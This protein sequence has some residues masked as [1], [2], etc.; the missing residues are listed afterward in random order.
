VLFS[1]GRGRI[2]MGAAVPLLTGD[3]LTRLLQTLNPF[4][5]Q[6][7]YSDLECSVILLTLEEGDGRMPVMLM[8]DQRV[9]VI[10]QGTADLRNEK[11]GIEFKTQPRQG[12]GVSA[13]MFVTPFVVVSGTFM[14]PT[15]G[16]NKR[17]VLL[18][19]GAA[20]LT[21]GLSIV[22]EALLSRRKRVTD[23]CEVAGARARSLIE[24]DATD[25]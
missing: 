18:H 3:L 8:Q 10:G 20:F 25:D 14:R 1:Q 12:I 5:R 6:T 19:G 23:P 17:S 4:S 16:M 11:L 9:Q 24:A 2:D 15:L 21:G 13:D 7:P 22:G